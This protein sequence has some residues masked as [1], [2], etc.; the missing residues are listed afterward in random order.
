VGGAFSERNASDDLE[1][2]RLIAELHYKNGK[3]A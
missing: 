2:K 3:T 1:K